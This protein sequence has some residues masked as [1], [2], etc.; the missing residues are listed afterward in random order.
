MLAD[1][2]VAYAFTGHSFLIAVAIVLLALLAAAVTA[3]FPGTTLPKNQR[4]RAAV[5]LSVFCL[6]IV[7]TDSTTIRLATGYMP[8]VFRPS[9]YR[10]MLCTHVRVPR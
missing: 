9:R 6:L 4:L 3:F 5:A 1:I 8:G 2:D 7:S 10:V